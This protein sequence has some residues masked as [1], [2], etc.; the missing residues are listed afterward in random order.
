MP[1]D[2]LRWEIQDAIER[3]NEKAKM[4]KMESELAG[5]LVILMLPIIFGSVVALAIFGIPFLITMYVYV[6]IVRITN[7]VLVGTIIN[8]LISLGITVIGILILSFIV[9]KTKKGFNGKYLIVYLAIALLIPWASVIGSAGAFNSIGFE[10]GNDEVLYLEYPFTDM[11]F[12]DISE[13]SQP[14]TSPTV[15]NFGEPWNHNGVVFFVDRVDFGTRNI[16]VRYLFINLT[17]ENLAFQYETPYGHY[18]LSDNTGRVY[19][20]RQ[21]LYDINSDYGRE[22]LAPSKNL[23][24][25]YNGEGVNF[26][27]KGDFF[28]KYRE[29]DYSNIEYFLFRM[30][31]VFGVQNAVWKIEAPK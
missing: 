20:F 19:A 8:T 30:D 17:D 9:T 16:Y 24:F 23:L 27:I 11:D 12:Y 4:D 2:D 5:G 18:T 25:S 7:N 15:L 21:S 1:K 14:I 26:V 31:G 3:A 29:I 22:L 6:N 10:Q 28:E 13:A